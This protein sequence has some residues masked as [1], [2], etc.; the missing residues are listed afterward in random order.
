MVTFT[1]WRVNLFLYVVLRQGF[2][3]TSTDTGTG[4]EGDKEDADETKE[5]NEHAPEDRYTYK[6]RWSFFVAL[7]FLIVYLLDGYNINS[8]GP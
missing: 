4:Q 1:E 7:H 8:K 2:D 3:S 6:C 5:K